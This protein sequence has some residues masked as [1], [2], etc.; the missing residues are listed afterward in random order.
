MV[1]LILHVHF[2]LGWDSFYAD[3]PFAGS[4]S[5]IPWFA[6]ST[7]SLLVTTIVLFAA[8]LGLT[9]IPKGNQHGLGVAPWAGVMAAVVFV[10][11]D[12]T[13]LR[14]D[15]NMWPIDLVLLS[16]MTGLPSRPRH[17]PDSSARP[18]F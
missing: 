13:R 18:F 12:T 14:Q 11:L 7:R 2:T 10:W 16:A 5:D 1:F 15:S 4:R 8:A 3:S 6:S 9:L 17:L